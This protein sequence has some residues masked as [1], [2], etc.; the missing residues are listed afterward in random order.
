MGLVSFLL[1]CNA[2]NL[3]LEI[4]KHGK[5][6]K[7][8]IY[9]RV[10]CQCWVEF[11]SKYV[12]WC[13]TSI[14]VVLQYISELVRRCDD[15]R[16]QLRRFTYPAS[17]NWQS[18]FHRRATA[19]VPG[20]HYHLALNWSPLVPASAINSRHTSSVVYSRNFLLV[21]STLLLVFYVCNYWRWIVRR[22]WAS[23]R[24][25]LQVSVMMMMMMTK[26]AIFKTE[27][28]IFW[29]QPVY[30]QSFSCLVQISHTHGWFR[31]QRAAKTPNFTVFTKFCG[32][33]AQLCREKRGC[34]L[35]N[36]KPSPTPRW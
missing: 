17:C 11:S 35:Y 3:V 32:G 8:T 25:A 14:T 27:F 2:S 13:L 21:F 6:W 10:H 20:M 36:Y 31:R 16:L 28:W 34:T 30:T 15:I 26:T 7:G 1:H 22:H 9:I 24:G 4:L 29:A 33:S 12:L 19:H 23:V 18:I 5:I